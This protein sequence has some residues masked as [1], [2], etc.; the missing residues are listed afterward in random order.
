[1]KV[2]KCDNSVLWLLAS[3]IVIG[4]FTVNFSLVLF[5]NYIHQEANLTFP[6]AHIQK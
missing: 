3:V 5:L 6:S 2:L 4:I 1:M